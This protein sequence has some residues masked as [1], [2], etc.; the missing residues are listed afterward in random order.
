MIG[1]FLLDAGARSHS[2]AALSEKYLNHT[3]IPISDLIGKGKNQ[4]SMAEIDVE[5]VAEYASEDADVS[6]QIAAMVTEEL[7]RDNLWDLYW[8]LEHLP[9]GT[10]G[11]SA[12]TEGGMNWKK[13]LPSLNS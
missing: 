9:Q 12:E 1:H 13:Y 7:E 2:L 6:W 8:E 5:Q 3:M 4:K 10:A 11:G